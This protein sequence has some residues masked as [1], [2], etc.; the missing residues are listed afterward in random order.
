MNKTQLLLIANPLG[1]RGVRITVSEWQ[2]WETI[3]ASLNLVFSV[4]GSVQLV[5]ESEVFEPQQGFVRH[6]AIEIVAQP[7]RF[8]LFVYPHTKL[9][10][11]S[12]LREWW[13]PNNDIFRGLENF[14][15]EE[16]DSRL[17]CEDVT[18][19]KKL[20]SEFYSERKITQL[21]LETTI[22]VW[23]PKPRT[24]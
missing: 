13:Q 22:S 10:E 6:D 9:G 23:T 18:V 2:A 8:R 14:G 7:G 11:R 5:T 20:F 16:C 17:I 3:E 1:S 12:N 24:E 4:G 19:A 21:L 15:E